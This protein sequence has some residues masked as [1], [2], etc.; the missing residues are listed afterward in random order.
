LHKKPLIV[1]SIL[2]VVLLI[3]V[4]LVNVVGYQTI[5]TPKQNLIKER[6][7]Q[8]ELLFQT[9]VDL[10]NNKE[11]QQ[12]IQNSQM[13]N[14]SSLYTDENLPKPITK[15]QLRRMYVIGLLL[16]KTIG[17]SRIQSMIQKYQLIAPEIKQKIDANKK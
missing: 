11:I 12:I 4:S 15:Q 1:V 17:K 7:N 14:G 6:I 9:T 5:Q 10:A 3:L 13:M 16:S 8:K 2:T